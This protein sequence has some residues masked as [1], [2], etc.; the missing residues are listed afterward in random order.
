MKWNDLIHKY[1]F[2]HECSNYSVSRI[3]VDGRLQ[4]DARGIVSLAQQM[5]LFPED[6]ELRGVEAE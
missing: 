2:Y 3:L 4:T 1:V 6:A 5:G